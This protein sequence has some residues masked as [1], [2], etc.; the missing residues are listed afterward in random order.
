MTKIRFRHIFGP[1]LYGRLVWFGRL[2]WLAVGGLALASL[3]GR[4]FDFGA[5]WPSLFFVASVVSG[6]NLE[7]GAYKRKEDMHR[8]AE[9]NK[10]FAHFRI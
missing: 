5:V 1:E 9:A 6:Y 3:L 10:S 8:M 2:R 4:R 7:G